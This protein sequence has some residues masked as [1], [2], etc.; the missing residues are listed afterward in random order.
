MV[1]SAALTNIA[2]LHLTFDHLIAHGA[3]SAPRT[4]DE[5]ENSHRCDAGDY[6]KDDDG[7]QE[8]NHQERQC[9]DTGDELAKPC[10]GLHRDVYHAHRPCLTGAL[11]S[12]LVGKLFHSLI[13]FARDR[14]ADYE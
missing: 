12:R 1:Q 3:P 11:R 8:T 10:F 5:I 13:Q 6:S 4:P 14:D 2:T 7:D 9:R